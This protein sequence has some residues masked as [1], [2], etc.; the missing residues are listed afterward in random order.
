MSQSPPAA[1]SRTLLQRIGETALDL[2]W[3]GGAGLVSYGADQAWRPGGFIVAGV[4]V[5]FATW[6]LGKS[7]A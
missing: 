2:T 5:L 3:I 4:F 1:P 6:R 7:I